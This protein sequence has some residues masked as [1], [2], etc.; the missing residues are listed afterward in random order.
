MTSDFMSIIAIN[1]ENMGCFWA[2][3]PWWQLWSEIIETWS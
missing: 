2:A 3:D 1:D